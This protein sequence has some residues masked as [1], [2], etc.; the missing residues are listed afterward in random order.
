LFFI[1]Y[2]GFVFWDFIPLV[3]LPLA[4]L[5]SWSHGDID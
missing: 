2:L 5:F 3:F 4:V 1:W